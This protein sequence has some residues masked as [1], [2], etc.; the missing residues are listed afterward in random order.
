MFPG[1]RVEIVEGNIVMSPVR[2]FNA[3]TIR[4]L[5]NQLEPQLSDEWGIISDVAMPFSD[6]FELCPD[7]AVIPAAEE[8]RNLSAYAPGPGG[9]R[10]R[11]GVSE[12]R[13]Q[14]LRG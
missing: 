13:P 7:L 8:S 11:G 10:H 12:Q 2:P 6:E 5:W 14:R 1:Y 4:L 9:S 3:R